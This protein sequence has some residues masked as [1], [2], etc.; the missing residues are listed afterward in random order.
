MN[1]VPK[2]T[3]GDIII[4]YAHWYDWKTVL[5]ILNNVLLFIVTVQALSGAFK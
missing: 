4:V 5:S 1:S 2:V 3:E